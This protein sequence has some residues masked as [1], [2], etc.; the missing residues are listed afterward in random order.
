MIVG[1]TKRS[2]EA[3]GVKCAPSFSRSLGSSALQQR[4]KDR[5]LN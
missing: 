4:A 5:W 3:G 1:T 2:T